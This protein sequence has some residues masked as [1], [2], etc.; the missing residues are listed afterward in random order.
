MRVKDKLRTVMDV[1]NFKK[2]GRIPK[3]GEFKERKGSESQ[4]SVERWK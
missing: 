4:E 3:K 2:R 1:L